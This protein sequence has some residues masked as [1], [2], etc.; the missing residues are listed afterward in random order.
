MDLTGSSPL[1]RSGMVDF[2]PGHAVAGA[3]KRKCAKYRDL[4]ASKGY[5]FLPF[6]FSTL[7]ELDAEVVVLLK[8]V[9]E[10]Q[11]FQ[12][13]KLLGRKKIYSFKLILQHSP[14]SWPISTSLW[15]A[16]RVE[17]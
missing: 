15:E 4:C 17:I 11:I 9:I 12:N 13:F 5:I 16:N 8:R 3:A 14:H 6:S 1:T 10:F 2:V 7:G